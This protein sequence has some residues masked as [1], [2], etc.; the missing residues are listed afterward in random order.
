M[1]ETD[2]TP[3]PVAPSPR[4]FLIPSHSIVWTYGLLGIN[5]VVFVLTVLEGGGL[6]VN[7]GL[8]PRLVL[9]GQFWRLVTSAFLHGDIL[10]IF[11]NLYALYYLGLHIERHF[12]SLR[13]LAVYAFALLGASVFVLLFSPLDTITVGASGAIMGV[14]GGL[15]IYYW[16]HRDFI[17]GGRQN[18]ERLVRVAVLN[19]AIGLLPQVSL[20]GHLG[21]FLAGVTLSWAIYPRYH[22]VADPEP[23]LEV[24]PLDKNAWGATG[25]VVVIW[26]FLLIF[27]LWIRG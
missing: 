12:G 22:G 5:L 25:I 27:S 4:Q 24:A 19:L 16:K 1:Y 17:A 3:P 23:H 13:F 21:G 26:L 6:V 8:I 15:V 11:T 10:H 2:I 7:G 20:W 9:Y 18:L 14:L